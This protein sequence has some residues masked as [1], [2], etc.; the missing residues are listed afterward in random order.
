LSGIDWLTVGAAG[1]ASLLYLSAI[2]IGRYL[3]DQPKG[4]SNF[5]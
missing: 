4:W 5:C 3:A 1:D 2:T